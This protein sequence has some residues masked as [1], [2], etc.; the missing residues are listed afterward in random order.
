MVLYNANKVQIAKRICHNV[1]LVIVISSLGPLGDT[2]VTVYILLSLLEANV[3]NNWRYLVRAWHIEFVYCNVANFC[4]YEIQ[5][6][7][8]SRITILARGQ[9]VNKSMLYN[10]LF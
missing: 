6:K 4:H 7:Y 1:N 9:V 5:A 10:S 2:H 8:N 3:S